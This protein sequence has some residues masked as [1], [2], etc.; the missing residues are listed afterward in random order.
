MTKDILV[1][2]LQRPSTNIPW[3]FVMCGGRDQGLTFKIG[4]VKRMTPASRAGLCKMDYLISINGRPVFNLNHADCVRE[5]KSAG[6]TLRL[7]CERGDHIVPSFDEMFPGLRKDDQLDGT[8]RKKFIGQE[9]YQ[10]AMQN[11]GLG[12]MPQPDNFT[13][14]GNTL[15]IEITQYNCPIQAYSEGALDEMRS[16]KERGGLENMEMLARVPQAKKERTKFDP[17]RSNAILAIQ[18]EEKGAGGQHGKGGRS[19]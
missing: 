6:A 10:D 12:H 17:A 2:D 3:G 16:Q 15:G 5:I 13:T 7:E 1:F 19:A 11:H 9:Y 4:N 14:V 8:S 18:M